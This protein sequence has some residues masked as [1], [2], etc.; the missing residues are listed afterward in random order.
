MYE[1]NFEVGGWGWGPF[2]VGDGGG[3]WMH[4]LFRYPLAGIAVC[5]GADPTCN[6][7]E[8]SGSTRLL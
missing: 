8:H 2:E 6:H 4:L 5:N 7:T 1:G 3:G